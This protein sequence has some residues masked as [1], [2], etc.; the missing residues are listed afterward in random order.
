MGEGIASS[1]LSPTVADYLNTKHFAE[2]QRRQL[3]EE[4]DEQKRSVVRQQV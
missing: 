4:I 2:E 1:H 3:Q